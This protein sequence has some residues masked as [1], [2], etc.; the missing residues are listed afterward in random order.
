MWHLITAR[1]HFAQ[2]FNPWKPI[3]TDRYPKCCIQRLPSRLNTMALHAAV[4]ALMSYQPLPTYNHTKSQLDAELFLIE[5][6]IML[7]SSW[8]R[9]LCVSSSLSISWQNELAVEICRSLASWCSSSRLWFLI[10]IFIKGTPL[11]CHCS[12]SVTSHRTACLVRWVTKHA[13]VTKRSTIS[14]KADQKFLIIDTKTVAIKPP[15]SQATNTYQEERRQQRHGFCTKIA[16]KTQQVVRKRQI[17]CF[18]GGPKPWMP[19]IS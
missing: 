5:F 19:E 2:N 13:I 15:Q 10:H 1:Q 11:S 6:N 12:G 18:S 8:K 14:D 17:E 4:T 16:L 3:F 7:C 9:I